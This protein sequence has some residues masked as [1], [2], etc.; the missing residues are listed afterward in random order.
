[1]ASTHRFVSERY[2]GNAELARVQI[3]YH[4]QRCS[5]GSTMRGSAGR[6]DEVFVS[7]HVRARKGE[8][9]AVGETGW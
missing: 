5:L 8:Y 2:R 7:V 9:G 6:S 3:G 1:M 4:V